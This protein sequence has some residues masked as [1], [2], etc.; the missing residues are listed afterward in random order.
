MCIA[1]LLEKPTSKKYVFVN[2]IKYYQPLWKNET[3]LLKL[4][5]QLTYKQK[6]KNNIT[7]TLT[8]SLKAWLA[9]FINRN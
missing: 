6:A 8:A 4:H 2:P 9:K 7:N 5:A 3:K 1:D